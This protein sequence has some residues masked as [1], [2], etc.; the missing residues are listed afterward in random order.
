MLNNHLTLKKRL[1]NGE[2]LC[3]LFIAEFRSPSM[4]LILE[5]AGYD[6]GLV[7][8]EHGAFSLSDMSAMI[9]N[10]RALKTQPIVRI[11]SVSKDYIQ[12]LLDLGVGG[13]VIPMAENP[14]EIRRCVELMRYPPEGRRGM[15]FCCPH[16]GFVP[17]DRDEYMKMA[18]ENLLMIAMIETA[19]G[20]ENLDALLDV[21]GLDAVIVGNCDLAISMGEENDLAAGPVHDAMCH[22]LRSAEAKGIVGGGNFA[23]PQSAAKFLDL[24]L[25]LIVLSSEVDRLCTSLRNVRQTMGRVLENHQKIRKT[26]LRVS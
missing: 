6:F 2:T 8:M 14:D 24:G 19:R 20:V 3:G 23:D 9:P 1:K 21:P 25:R 10:F 4:G 13:L 18:N 17:R 11:P 12:P 15:S 5:G 7:D 26:G 22:V 16:G